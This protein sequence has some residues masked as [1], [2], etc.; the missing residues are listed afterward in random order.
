L[1]GLE[2]EAAGKVEGRIQLYAVV[3]VPS[4]VHVL[5]AF[6]KVS[7]VKMMPLGHQDSQNIQAVFK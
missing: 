6:R 4:T 7:K 3:R 1:G 5:A 2:N